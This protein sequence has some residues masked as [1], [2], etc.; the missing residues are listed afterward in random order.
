[1]RTP[2]FASQNKIKKIKRKILLK[3]VFKN[4]NSFEIATSESGHISIFLAEVEGSPY[5]KMFDILK[6][7]WMYLKI[8]HILLF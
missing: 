8:K 2:L 1:M 5:Y 4:S 3:A 7:A 6:R